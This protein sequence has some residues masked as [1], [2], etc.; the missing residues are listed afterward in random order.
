MEQGLTLE[1]LQQ[2]GVKQIT[3]KPEQ[4]PKEAGFSLEEMQRIGAKEIKPKV[5]PQFDVQG[6]KIDPVKYAKQQQVEQNITE[7]LGNVST[8]RFR[9]CIM[10]MFRVCELK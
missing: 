5:I 7:G 8:R 10:R 6:R 3:P 2:M 4:Q 1:Q 9:E